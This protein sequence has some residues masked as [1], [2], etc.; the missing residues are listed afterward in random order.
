[1]RDNHGERTDPALEPA[2]AHGWRRWAA[3]LGHYPPERIAGFGGIVVL[4]FGAGVV[5]LYLLA[6]LT[7]EVMSQETSALDAAALTYLQQFSSPTLTQ[8]MVILS[9]LGSEVVWALG[10]VLLVAFILQRRWGAG[11]MLVLVTAGAQVLNDILK[12]VFHRSRPEA[13]ASGILAVQQFS[14]PSG[15]AMISAAFYSYLAYVSWQL[16]RGSLRVVLVV[17]LSVLVILIGVSRIYL[18]AHYLSDVIAGYLA[19]LLWTD[20]V[21]LGSRLLV[22]YTRIRH[23][24][25]RV[26]RAVSK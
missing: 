14:F 5:V 18:G 9:L 20:S 2:P 19:G 7:E 1:V 24:R 8:V 16:I 25:R 23:A 13:W 26:A 15:H 10:G 17:G 3:E 22:P 6:W 21:I 4:G 11:G 12:G